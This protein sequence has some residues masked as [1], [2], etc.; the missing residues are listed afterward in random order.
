MKYAD[1]YVESSTKPLSNNDIGYWV[2]D[3]DDRS[4]RREKNFRWTSLLKETEKQ[5]KKIREWWVSLRRVGQ[6][7]LSRNCVFHKW[8]WFQQCNAKPF[9]SRSRNAL[10]LDSPLN[11]LSAQTQREERLCFHYLFCAFP[12]DVRDKSSKK[13]DE[14]FNWFTLFDFVCFE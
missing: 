13:A 14:I 3:V 8:P 12:P 6:V 10:R 11:A 5:T 2:R 7:P 9:L 4:L 1:V